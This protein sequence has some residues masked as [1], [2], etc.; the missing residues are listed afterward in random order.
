MTL[1]TLSSKELKPL[2]KWALKRNRTIMIIYSIFLAVFGPILDMYMAT[3]Y[4]DASSSNIEEIGI[5]SLT[6][7]QII[8]AFFTFVS[9]LKT[10]S[11]LHNKRSVDMF[12]ALPTN[13][14]TMYVS[15]L[16]A[17][18]T[19]IVLPYIP[20]AVLTLGITSRSGDSLKLGLFCVG[21]TL[22]MIIAAYV[23]TS[24]IAYCCGTIIDTAIVTVAVNAVWVGV[25]ALYYGF[26]YEMIPGME[27]YNIMDTP[28]I[29]LFAPYGFSLVE[30]VFYEMDQIGNIVTLILWNIVYIAGIF[31]LALYAA[32][33]RK[34]ETSQNG[35][36]VQWL[37]MVIKAGVSVACGGFIGFVAAMISY[38]GYGNMFVFSFWYVIIGFVAFAI[39]HIIFAR[40]VKGKII[41]SLITYICTSV[42]ALALVFGLSFGMGLDTYV[43]S[44]N[45]VSSVTFENEEFSDPENIATITEIHKVITEGIRNYYD[46]PYYLGDEDYNYYYDDYYDVPAEDDKSDAELNPAEKYP[47]VNY[48]GFSFS[49]KRKFGFGVSRE[50][51]IYTYNS[52]DHTYDY[53]TLNELLKKLYSSEEYKIMKNKELFDD[54]TV[55]K[56]MSASLD[57]YYY[58]DGQYMNYGS[59][60]LPSDAEFMT[61]LRQALKADIIADQSFVPQTSYSSVSYRSQLFYRYIGSNCI[62]LDIKY[63]YNED[64]MQNY[65]YNYYYDYDDA[66][67]RTR[68]YTVSALI[69]PNYVNTM[70]YLNE[71]NIVPENSKAYTEYSSYYPDSYYEFCSNG[72]FD[73]LS[74]MVEEISS[75]WAMIAC[76]SLNVDYYDWAESNLKAYNKDVLV[77]AEELYGKYMKDFNAED[78]QYKLD[79][80]DVYVYYGDYTEVAD[81]IIDDLLQYTFEYVEN[82]TKVSES[83]DTDTNSDK[84]SDSDKSTDTSA[85][86]KA[87][88]VPTNE[89]EWEEANRPKSDTSSALT[90]SEAEELT[91]SSA[92]V[93]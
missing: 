27:F 6:L 12:G 51:Y 84:G 13:R 60:D 1:T 33:K 8:A 11:Y 54:E 52:Y 91:A 79:G 85:E 70:K 26:I 80:D 21:T 89:S 58:T 39:L 67:T 48:T 38:S 29:V 73:S 86:S 22:L 37:P 4:Y 19:A 64:D 42:A 28:L 61:G 25:I 24:L 5:V 90:A 76:N 50:Y 59:A 3:Q 40:G 55:D 32:N 63:R 46:Y 20:A 31:F 77:K 18:I 71:H 56:V 93:V 62:E 7:F 74:V 75:K 10:F 72:D 9:A 78:A 53:N 83:S 16:L 44:A 34:A 45:T 14:T 92:T 65:S 87:S 82:S 35:F 41:P 66:I 69:K 88:S 2:Y 49:Y 30:L 36:A 68:T 23:F 43:P 81:N 15:H 57:Y 17:G 47:Y